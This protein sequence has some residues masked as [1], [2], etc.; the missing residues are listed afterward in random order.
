[1][2]L[3]RYPG[4]KSKLSAKILSKINPKKEYREPFFGGGAIGLEVMKKYSHIKYWINDVDVGIYSIWNAVWENPDELIDLIKSF[5]PSVDKFYEFQDYLDNPVAGVETGFKK[6]AIH[7]ISYSGL[8]I[9]SGGPLGGKSQKS[10]YKIDCRW[11][12]EY[13]EKQIRVI[14]ALFQSV[15]LKITCVDYKNLIDGDA[16]IYLDPTYY[17]KGN[18]LY[19]HG[20]SEEDHGQL[21]ELLKKKN[22][23]LLSYDDC[24]EIIR[25]YSWAKI[26]EMKLN[27]SI[28]NSR[29]K[30][31]LLIFPF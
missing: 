10:K 23:W 30:T 22:N 8:G 29:Q 26:E 7:Q 6:L 3:F 14:H 16:F 28:T 11:S 4:G 5:V 12:P 13:L 1:M 19:Q 18:D 31:E 24:P 2:S 15:D 20:F 17:V 25:L 21:A 27:Y 9:K